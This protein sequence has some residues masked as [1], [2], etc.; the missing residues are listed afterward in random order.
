MP[1]FPTFSVELSD[2]CRTQS[3]MSQD[4]RDTIFAV[5]DRDGHHTAKDFTPKSGLV[6]VGGV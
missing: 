6:M 3:N 1:A 4:I 2:G 5:M